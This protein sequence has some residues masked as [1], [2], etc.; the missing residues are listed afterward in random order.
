MIKDFKSH[1]NSISIFSDKTEFI[2]FLE[3]LNSE[4]F[5]D[6][7]VFNI[8]SNLLEKYRPS[9]YTDLS[10]NDLKSINTKSSNQILTLY[11]GD[12]I[13][14]DNENEYLDSITSIADDII[15]I[16]WSNLSLNDINYNPRSFSWLKNKM[17]IRGFELDVNLN[18]KI[19]LYFFENLSNTSSIYVFRRYQSKSTDE[20][21]SKIYEDIPIFTYFSDYELEFLESENKKEDNEYSLLSYLTNNQFENPVLPLKITANI[22]TQP[23]RFNSLLEMLK[24]I[25]GQFDEIRIYLNNYDYIPDELRKYTTFIG[26]DIADN[27]KFY[28]SNNK[29]EYYFTLDDDIIYPPNYVDKTIP[30]IKD[31]IV[32][33]HGRKLTGINK[34]YFSDHKLYCFYDKLDNEINIDVGGTGVMAFNTN[35]F[36]PSLWKTPIKKDSDL[37]ISMEA[38]FYSTPIVC[39]PKK[40]NWIKSIENKSGIYYESILNQSRKNTLSEIIQ[41]WKSNERKLESIIV[42]LN[43]NRDSNQLIADLIKDLNVNNFYHFGCSDGRTIGHLSNLLDM[44]YVGIDISSQRINHCLMKY[45]QS[46]IKFLHIHYHEIPICQNSFILMNDFYLLDNHTWSIWNNMKGNSFILTTKLLDTTPVKKL[47]IE[48]SIGLVT[49]YLYKKNCELISHSFPYQKA[50]VISMQDCELSKLRIDIFKR[51]SVNFNNIEFFPATK[52]RTDNYKLYVNDE[53]D[54]YLFNGE[55]H[56]I[57]RMTDGEIGC[58]MS[59]L[60]IWKKIV[61]EDIEYALILE[62]DASR[63]L[64]GIQYYIDE[65]F[66]SLPKDF[67]IFLLGFWDLSDVDEKVSENISRVR[68][69]LLSHSYIISKNCAKKIIDEF[70]PINAPLDTFLSNLADKLKIYRH[71][72]YDT[73]NIKKPIKRSYLI[74]QSRSFSLIGKHTNVF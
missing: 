18:N 62:D 25:D 28:W 39:L 56:E 30:L 7:S 1:Y 2:E 57:I 14:R 58:A 11:I 24:S 26:E 13:K 6:K 69:F 74:N 32:T 66:K 35:V 48:L 63:T 19:N 59:H 27:G 42:Q 67:D 60:R 37:V 43:I 61:S 52:G 20:V 5:L 71:N 23:N 36:S 34:T 10:L 38:T 40:E 33:Y 3:F 72:L 46:N 44:E 15:I 9:N 31:R 41:I 29:D 21:I 68:R 64:P 51:I 53:W 54:K 17:E 4:I 8:S 55:K 22:A 50:F 65:Y 47:D 16:G 70:L 73:T 12:E 49:H 45:K